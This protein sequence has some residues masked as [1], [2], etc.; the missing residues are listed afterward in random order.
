MRWL[1]Y[2]QNTI[3]E[4]GME[5]EGDGRSSEINKLSC[6]AAGVRE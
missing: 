6:Q 4:F 2:T 5:A 1:Q 3:V